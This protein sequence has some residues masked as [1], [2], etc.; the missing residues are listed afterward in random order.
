LEEISLVVTLLEKG[1]DIV[2]R[3]GYGVVGRCLV[4]WMIYLEVMKRDEK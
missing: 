2:V 3:L 1:W 4:F